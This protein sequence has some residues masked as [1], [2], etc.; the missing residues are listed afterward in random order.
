MTLPFDAN[1]APMA[2]FDLPYSDDAATWAALLRWTPEVL[3]WPAPPQEEPW[4]LAAAGFPGQVAGTRIDQLAF[5]AAIEGHQLAF[6]RYDIERVAVPAVARLTERLPWRIGDRPSVQAVVVGLYGPLSLGLTLVD[7]D[8]RP[9]FENALMHEV[10]TQHLA[11]RMSWLESQLATSLI[12]LIEPFW[13][14]IGSPFIAQ[15]ADDVLQLVLEAAAPLNTPV[16]LAPSGM[17]DWLPILRSALRLIVCDPSQWPALLACGTDV[18]DYFE[19]GGVVAWALV[20]SDPARLS[21]LSA[22][23]L[24]AE[25]DALLKQA[26]DQDVLNSL[27]LSGSL[28][29]VQPGLRQQGTAT[30]DQALAILSETSRLIRTR[31]KL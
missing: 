11:L 15:S 2:P 26:I 27:I 12:C 29:T 4:Y 25:W 20:P 10:I 5:E 3:T 8:D 22:S 31:Y 17:V 16:G 9:L 30:A 23:D 1:C 18:N 14:A 21:R 13:A 7:A 6:L 24:V 19:R 28:L